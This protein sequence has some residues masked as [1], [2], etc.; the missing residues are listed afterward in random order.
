M[1]EGMH[2]D[3]DRRGYTIRSEGHGFYRVLDLRG[4]IV[5]SCEGGATAAQIVDEHIDR[6]YRFW[7]VNCDLSPIQLRAARK[8][9]SVE[10]EQILVKAVSS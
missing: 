3:I 4:N 9:S 8:L 6:V 10:A 5:G 2:Q 7:N 1:T